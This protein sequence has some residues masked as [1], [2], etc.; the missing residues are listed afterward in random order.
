MDIN[1]SDYE[2]VDKFYEEVL[3]NDNS[4]GDISNGNNI[5]NRDLE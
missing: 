5:G 2:K 1:K 4:G 3:G